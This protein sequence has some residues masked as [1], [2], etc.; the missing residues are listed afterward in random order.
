LKTRFSDR[1]RQTEIDN[2]WRDTAVILPVHHDVTGFDV[3]VN[4]VQL[5]Q[6]FIYT[7]SPAFNLPLGSLRS[8]YEAVQ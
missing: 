3:P 8:F 1:L 6:L 7:Q 4:E 5:V 2:F